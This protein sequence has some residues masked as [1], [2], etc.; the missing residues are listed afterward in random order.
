[1]KLSLLIR[2]VAKNIVVNLFWLLDYKF[3]F[4][5]IFYFWISSFTFTFIY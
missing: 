4:W 1:M 2:L 5:G 3:V